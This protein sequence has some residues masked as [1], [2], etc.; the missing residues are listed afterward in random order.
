MTA[1][2]SLSIAAFSLLAPCIL[3]AGPRLQWGGEK[4]RDVP[5]SPRRLIAE[6]HGFRMYTAP[7]ALRPTRDSRAAE[8]GRGGAVA[9]LS[10]TQVA[11]SDPTSGNVVL[12]VWDE[13]TPNSSGV[14]VLVN[15]ILIGAVPG[16]PEPDTNSVFLEGFPDGLFTL[17]VESIDDGSRS[18]A[19]QLFVGAQPFSDAANVR[20]SPG[21][22]PGPDACSLE[23]DWENPGPAPEMYV[24][25]LNGINLGTIPGDTLA[26]SI[27]NAPP[28]NYAVTLVGFDRSEEGQGEYRGGFVETSC[29]LECAVAA[30]V[31]TPVLEEFGKLCLLALFLGLGAWPL[32]RAPAPAGQR[33]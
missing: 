16:R 4:V 17:Q 1:R 25:L 26:L 7:G 23:V 22:V 33:A 6:R 31:E 20:C 13:T 27:E 12:L 21:D 15:N 8:R 9:G 5:D 32:R 30:P 19:S 28:R 24:V 14:N 10:T 2:I 11:Y 29:I 3:A 18:E